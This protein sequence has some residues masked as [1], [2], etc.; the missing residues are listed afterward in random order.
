MLYALGQPFVSIG[1]DGAAISPDGAYA[2]MNPHP[3]WYGTFPRVLGRYVR[4]LGK[5]TLPEAVLKMTSM[6][7]EKVGILDRGRIK[8]GFRADV[9]LFDPKTVID[10]ATFE[11]SQ[12]YPVGI[13]YVIVNGTLVLDD[14]EHTGEL[15]G[16]VLRGPGYEA[17]P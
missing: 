8:E 13:P 7:A 4:E 16:M 6:N 3:R 17:A 14:N 2:D 1:S 5:L 12:Q 15:P 11:E 9:T 10:R